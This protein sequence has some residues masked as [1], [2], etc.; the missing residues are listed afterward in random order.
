MFAKIVNI[1]QVKNQFY[2]YV[3][4]IETL[5][6]ENYY[7]AY[8]VNL[9]DSKLTNISLVNVNDLPDS[10]PCIIHTNSDG[11]FVATRYDV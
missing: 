10:D 11:T 5:D 9:L 7:H 3:H 8:E 4:S 2:F 1:Y 6:F